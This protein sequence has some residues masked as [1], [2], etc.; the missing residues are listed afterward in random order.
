MSGEDRRDVI[1]VV[2]ACALDRLLGVPTYPS[3]DAKVRTT[4]YHEMG[5]GNAANTATAMARLSKKSHRIQLLSKVGDD[6][7][8]RQIMKELKTDGVDL[9]SSLFQVGLPGSTTSHCTVVVSTQEAT[10]TCIFTPGTCGELTMDDFQKADM[11]KVFERVVHLHSDARHTQVA[12]ALAQEA[13]RRGIPISLD[14]EKDRK[15][16]AL[17]E[18]LEAA[19][20]VFT[21][22][23]RLED[24]LKR[25]KQE[26]MGT[27]TSPTI[28]AE[29][30]WKGND[31]SICCQRDLHFY[32]KVMEPSLFFTRCY[33][34]LG[35]EVI[36][37]QGAKGAVHVVC[38]TIDS[39][40]HSSESRME[41]I[42]SASPSSAIEIRQET[43]AYSASYIVE[44]VGVLSNLNI[45]DTTGAGDAFIGGFIL[46]KLWGHSTRVSLAF[47]AW[48]GGRKLE[49]PG[50]RQALPDMNQMTRELGKDTSEIADSLGRMVGPFKI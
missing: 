15:S 13:K 34:Q 5:G 27:T 48:V 25:I 4:S 37:T 21:N 32:A 2:G 24:Y 41:I 8:G 38:N 1:L 19:T 20:L 31:D 40:R 9:S 6:V 18:L 28:P 11:D 44:A 10:R 29:T 26:I 17:D 16:K 46:A 3:A 23:D 30:A 7:V 12:L 42:A 43:N 45:I 49:G 22:A 47:G 50:S 33:R 35:K 36:I 14:V 39:T